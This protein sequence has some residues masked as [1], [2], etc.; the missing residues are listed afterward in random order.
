[1]IACGAAVAAAESDPPRIYA[2][3]VDPREHPDYQRRAVRPPNWE[4]FENRTHLN[5]LRYLS[6]EGG[7]VV[8]Y[9]E[10]MEQ[11]TKAYRLGDV[12]SSV[13][14][15]L[16]AKNLGDLVDELRRRKLYLFGV[17]GYVPGMGPGSFYEQ[18][19]TPPAAL[20]L[21]DA[22]LGPRWLSMDVGEQD[23][24]YIG[25]YAPQMYPT[26]ASRLEQYFNFQ[27]HFERLTD[28]LGNKAS[29]LLSLNFGHHLL[30]EGVYTLVGAETAQGCR[31]ARFTMPSSAA[32]ASNT[33]SSRS[34]SRRSTIAGATRRTAE[35]AST[36][37]I[38]A[39]DRPRARASAC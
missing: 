20:S 2:H 8:H 28:D 29:A 26:S 1:M 4:T 16:F 6:V 12:V 19:K 36:S 17:C 24:R 13:Y 30:K 9:A 31:T 7:R 33:A 38:I 37:S 23:G 21:F 10:D 22:K 34:T 5:G 32:P 3:L 27:R 15:I 14:P 11:Y 39:T 25:L 35:K 18:F